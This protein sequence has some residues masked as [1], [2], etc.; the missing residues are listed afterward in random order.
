MDR[1]RALLQAAAPRCEDDCRGIRREE[2]LANDPPSTH[3]PAGVAPR[4]NIVSV[5]LPVVAVVLGVLLIVANPSGRGDYFG[6]LG[7]AVLFIVGVTVACAIGEVAA[8]VALVRGERLAWL[9]ILGIVGN[10]A[11]IVPVL[12]LF[13]KG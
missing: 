11:V 9:T 7:A 6:G 5:A 2:N 4:W 1:A 13:L 10:G 3:A 12:A 8:W